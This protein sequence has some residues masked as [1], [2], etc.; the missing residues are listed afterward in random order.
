MAEDQLHKIA[1]MVRNSKHPISD[2]TMA[3]RPQKPLRQGIEK[4]IAHLSGEPITNAPW[5]LQLF[6]NGEID[7]DAELSKRFPNMPVMSTFHAHT[8]GTRHATATHATQDGAA[9]VLVDVDAVTRNI[10]FVFA[11]RS[12]LALHFPLIDLGDM[13][14]SR[15]LELMRR[16]QGGLAFLWGK[17]RWENTYVICASHRYFTNIYAFSPNRFEAAARLTPDVSRS[18]VDWLDTYWKT[19][20]LD[21][22]QKHLTTW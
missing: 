4:A 15:W 12:M 7:L 6:F 5:I 9:T 8:V 17:A 13:D 3:A 21:D 18:L 14:R 22:S 2:Q 1:T 19:T 10:Q 20:P 11:F 16:D